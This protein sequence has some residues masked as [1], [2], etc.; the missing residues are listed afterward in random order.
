MRKLLSG[1]VICLI[2]MALVLGLAPAPSSAASHRE[3]PLISMDPTADITDF[4][5][6]R[7]YET[8]REDYIV[9][10]M[11]VIPGEE[12]SAGPNYYNFDP[13]VLYSFNIDN[14]QDGLAD[15]VR[16]EFEFKTEIRGVV[17]MLD[18][19]LSYVAL[20]PV[21]SLTGPGS[22]G[23]G[24]RQ[25]YTVTMVRGNQRRVIARNLIAVP[26]NVGPRTM[27]DYESLVQQGIYDL[28]DGGRVFAGQRDDPFYIDLGA[29][30]D[31]LNV[32][33]PGVDM[34]SGFNVH[35][36]ALEVP[37]SWL[38]DDEEGI[39][40]TE[41]PVLGAYASTYRRSTTVLRNSEDDS[42][43]RKRS[44]GSW[45][46]VQRLANPLVNEVII[47]TDDKDRWNSLDP[48]RERRFLKYYRNPTLLLALE[49][50]FGVDAEP[51]LDLRDVLLTYTPGRYNR[52]SEL[53]RL[54]ISVEPVPL[55][56][57]NRLTVLAGDNAG[58]PNGRRPLDDVTDVAIRVVGGPNFAD[59]GDNVDAN[60]LPL[61]DVFPFLPTP[62]DG[63]NRIHQNPTG[64]SPTT[65]PTVTPTITG[66]PPT[67]TPVITISPTGTGTGTP[68]TPPPPSV[69]PT[70]T[71]T[72]TP[73][74]TI[75]GTGSP[76]PSRTNTSTPIALPDLAIDMVRIE[77]ENISCLLPGAPLGVRV[78]FDNI[79]QADAGNFV[80]NVNGVTQ[81][82]GGLP[83]NAGQALFFA[84]AGNP[85]TITLDSTNLVTESD[86]TN[87][88]FSD[89]VPVP[90][91]PFPCTP[92]FTPSP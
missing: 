30:F 6:F 23:L 10:I 31:T 53:L 50:V 16:F 85:V 36:I 48:S 7:S 67:L 60:D 17:S 40:D 63:L 72:S 11:D 57:Q 47:G 18:L 45:V 74:M 43:D 92:T 39:P 80:V 14:D 54:D 33:N 65:P 81:T 4:F 64:G 58:W 20:P 29:I 62:W 56:S 41:S 21:T 19:F 38:T 55:A 86:E 52:L 87:N 3:A 42:A 70:R 89:M 88:T 46:Q 71:F 1:L 8:G 90:T 44:E 32:R 79:G 82:V 83:A 49:T 68:P 22:E 73:S 28:D 27:P 5:M 2:V 51:L 35:S 76:T 24:L 91:A 12:P 66:T 34:L 77:L 84:G 13:S 9:L 37:A 59:A 75:T 61:L 78:F 15:D 25:T 69:T 26:S